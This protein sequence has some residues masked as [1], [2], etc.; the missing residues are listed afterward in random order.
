MSLYY[1]PIFYGIHRYAA[2]IVVIII[3]II[4]ISISLQKMGCFPYI[5]LKNCEEPLISN[6]FRLYHNMVT[7]STAVVLA[8]LAVLTVLTVPSGAVGPQQQIAFAQGVEDSEGGEEIPFDD[9]KVVDGEEVIEVGSGGGE[10]G[11][12]E[13]EA[14]GDDFSLQSIFEFLAQFVNLDDDE[15]DDGGGAGEEEEEE[16]DGDNGGGEGQQNENNV[17]QQDSDTTQT[18]TQTQTETNVI[19]DRD[20]QG[21]E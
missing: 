20:V 7:K 6:N 19:V 8:I 14:G 13:E 10:G 12:E 4:I 21:G 15:G 5:G 18:R 9:V 3:I 2:S 11:G 17:E 1:H 16:E